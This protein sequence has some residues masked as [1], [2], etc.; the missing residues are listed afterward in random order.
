MLIFVCPHADIGEFLAGFYVGDEEE[1]DDS[2]QVDTE[3][4][5]ENIGNDGVGADGGN[6]D[7]DVEQEMMGQS[8]D[9][10]ND[11]TNVEQNA[12]KTQSAAVDNDATENGQPLATKENATADVPPQAAAGDLETSPF[13]KPAPVNGQ[14]L[15]TSNRP[16][17]NNGASL[18]LVERKRCF[19]CE[20]S[21]IKESSLRNHLKTDHNIV[22][23]DKGTKQVAG[24]NI[25]PN[26]SNKRKLD[27][28]SNAD[29]DIENR[30]TSSQQ[31]IDKRKC[32]KSTSETL[33]RSIA[34]V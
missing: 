14:L 4:T 33:P 24:K 5:N 2:S 20:E 32:V 30:E 26:Q 23:K 6:N 3:M 25:R 15:A 13:L 18:G 16:N 8:R 9:N 31:P 22:L 19:R 12:I 21:F 10:E 27:S 29:D 11:A 17:S 28:T 7:G 1:G 34:R